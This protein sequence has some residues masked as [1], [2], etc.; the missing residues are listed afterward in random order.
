MG[1]FFFFLLSGFHNADYESF[2][3][4]NKCALKCLDLACTLPTSTYERDDPR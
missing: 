4:G 2:M 3:F 1:V